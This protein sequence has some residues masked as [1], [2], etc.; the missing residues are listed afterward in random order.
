MIREIESIDV[1]IMAVRVNR[2]KRFT[3]DAYQRIL[4]LFHRR[5]ADMALTWYGD[6]VALI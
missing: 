6:A 1:A 2:L 3:L 4:T 5:D